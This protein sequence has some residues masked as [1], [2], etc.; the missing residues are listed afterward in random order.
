MGKAIPILMAQ[1]EVAPIFSVR[2][3]NDK[4]K[5]VMRCS[6]CESVS[7]ITRGNSFQLL[8]GAITKANEDIAIYCPEIHPEINNADVNLRHTLLINMSAKH[9]ASMSKHAQ[10]LR[11]LLF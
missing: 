10:H 5:P 9:V 1:G 11:K 7:E 2:D 6:R 8:P 4:G 3:V